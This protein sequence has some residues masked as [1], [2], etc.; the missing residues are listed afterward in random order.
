VTPEEAAKL[1]DEVIKAFAVTGKDE[2]FFRAAFA[3]EA[4]KQLLA[5]KITKEWPKTMM[6]ALE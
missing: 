2:K 3:G 1:A 5:Q 4:Y 6:E